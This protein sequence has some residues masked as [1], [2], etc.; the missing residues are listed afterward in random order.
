MHG[1]DQDTDGVWL[2]TASPTRNHVVFLENQATLTGGNPATSA[3]LRSRSGLPTSGDASHKVHSDVATADA[4]PDQQVLTGATVTLDGSGSSSAKTEPTLT[5]AWTQTSG[6]TVTLSSATAQ[7]PTF[8][9]PSVSDDLVFSLTVNDGGEN[10]SVPDTVTVTVRPYVIPTTAPCTH[11]HASDPGG[12]TGGVHRVTARTDSSLTL[13]TSDNANTTYELWF[14]KPDGTLTKIAN[15]V[16]PDHTVTVSDLSSL[17]TYWVAGRR[18]RAGTARWYPFQSVTTTGA[19]FIAAVDFTSSPASGDTYKIGETI[20]AQVTWRQPVTVDNGGSNDNVFLRLDL[21]ADDDDLTNSRRKMAWTGAG[22]GT[23]ILTFEYTVVAADADSDGMW[24]QRASATDDT[25][26]FLENGATITGG[27]PATSNAGRTH[28]AGD[29]PFWTAT[30]TL[31]D[32]SGGLGCDE[33]VP[34]ARCSTALTDYA[35]T[36]RGK[37]LPGCV[38]CL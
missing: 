38:R 27:D 21:G 32:L 1:T 8:T 22:S 2:Q 4:G 9:A 17:T 25:I 35:F 14:C 26:V 15:G 33:I 30:L 19:A 31:K 18:T 13:Q 12:G 37:I 24:L 36:N 10:S 29:T 34:E 3:V 16:G 20:R 5:Y 28:V 7:Q 23:D 6:T 11:P